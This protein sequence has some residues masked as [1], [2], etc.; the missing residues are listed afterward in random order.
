MN[1]SHTHTT[2]D[3]VSAVMDTLIERIPGRKRTY[4]TYYDLLEGNKEGLIARNSTSSLRRKLGKSAFERIAWTGNK[5]CMINQL[6][7]SNKCI[8][9]ALCKINVDNCFDNF[10]EAVTHLVVRLM[11]HS[12]W[13]RFARNFLMYAAIYTIIALR[14]GIVSNVYLSLYKKTEAPVHERHVIMIT[15]NSFTFQC[16]LLLLGHHNGG[17]L[18]CSDHCC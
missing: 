17:D 10:Q 4:M 3:T 2:Q 5:V 7:T 8:L 9:L 14:V 12:K 1:A 16:P 11:M 15:L 6:C 13:R 18:S